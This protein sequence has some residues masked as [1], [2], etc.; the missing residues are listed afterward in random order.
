MGGPPRRLGTVNLSSFVGV[1]LKL[2]DRLLQCWRTLNPFKPTSDHH[3]VMS[4]VIVGHNK[5][6]INT[7][8]LYKWQINQSSRRPSLGDDKMFIKKIA[9]ENVHQDKANRVLVNAIIES[10]NVKTLRKR[11][12]CWFLYHLYALIATT[13]YTLC[14][15]PIL[16]SPP[17]TG[18]WIMPKV[19]PYPFSW[20]ILVKVSASC[21]LA[22]FV[23]DSRKLFNHLDNAMTNCPMPFSFSRGIHLKTLVR[24]VSVCLSFL[25]CL[26]AHSLTAGTYLVRG[27]SL[28]LHRFGQH[29]TAR[30]QDHF[31]RRSYVR[32][33]CVERASR[34]PVWHPLIAAWQRIWFGHLS[35]TLFEHS[36][37]LFRVSSDHPRWSVVVT[38]FER[39]SA[40]DVAYADLWTWGYTLR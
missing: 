6:T 31:E 24:P 29:F 28:G 25:W 19:G 7:S 17:P 15:R 8:A 33:P 13:Q 2:T 23:I 36:A 27:F 4:R 10:F 30:E 34:P 14:V 35:S 3:D 12:R 18:D 5:Q 40:T 38:S 21:L 11:C 9:I 32:H 16:R 39:P 1:D 22:P 26:A 37:M 20:W